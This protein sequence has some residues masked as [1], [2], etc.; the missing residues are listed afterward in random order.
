MACVNFIRKSAASHGRANVNPVDRELP[1]NYARLWTTTTHIPGVLIRDFERH[2]GDPL[3]RRSS[4][5]AS[6]LTLYRLALP[7]HSGHD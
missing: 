4:H 7:T 5:R 2:R 3:R 1:D 6:R